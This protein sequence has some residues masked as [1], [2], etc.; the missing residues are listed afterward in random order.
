MVYN[1]FLG[2]LQTAVFYVT[3]LDMTFPSPEGVPMISGRRHTRLVDICCGINEDTTDEE[4]RAR[5]ESMLD[6]EDAKY[7]HQYGKFLN[8]RPGNNDTDVVFIIESVLV[9]TEFPDVETEWNSDD[10][11]TCMTLKEIRDFC[12]TYLEERIQSI[13]AMQA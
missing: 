2:F 4:R 11:N 13:A 3:M 8:G 1:S 7:R 9:F 6:I 12:K 10:D 5:V